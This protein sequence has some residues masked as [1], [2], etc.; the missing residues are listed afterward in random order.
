MKQVTQTQKHTIVTTAMLIVRIVHLGA[1][2]SPKTVYPDEQSALVN[3]KARW[4][5]VSA[6]PDFNEFIE[7]YSKKDDL[8]H[9]LQQ[10]PSGLIEVCNSLSSIVNVFDNPS[11]VKSIVED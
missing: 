2:M 1:T 7:V 8:Y 3:F 5:V 10:I 11:S 4:S 9:L 6:N